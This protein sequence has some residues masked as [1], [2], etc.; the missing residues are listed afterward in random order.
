MHA[1]KT[2]LEV[3]SDNVP[4]C[5]VVNGKNSRESLQNAG[6][7]ERQ[8]IVVK[9]VKAGHGKKGIDSGM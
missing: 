7:V 3:G 8:S 5:L 2:T 1:E 6:D 9:S 4:T